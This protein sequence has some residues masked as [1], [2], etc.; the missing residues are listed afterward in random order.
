MICGGD[1]YAQNDV[2]VS[3][4]MS[5]LGFHFTNN[6]TNAQ[7]DW[8][9]NGGSVQ[10]DPPNL[11]FS[12]TMNH[13]IKAHAL[14]V[15]SDDRMKSAIRDIADEEALTQL[16][17]IKPMIYGYKDKYENGNVKTI[18]YI[19]QQIKKIIPQAVSLCR[20]AI[21]NILTPAFVYMKKDTIELKL[22][23][24]LDDDIIL[25]CGSFLQVNIQDQN[26]EFALLSASDESII[27]AIGNENIDGVHDGTKAVIY[28]EV[29]DDFHC[30]DESQIF[31]ITTAAVQ[32][33]DRQLEAEKAKTALLQ[34]QM[35]D[36]LNRLA[37][38]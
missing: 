35:T 5:I 23:L 32:E 25:K 18:G 22:R 15:T 10:A 20:Q 16:R 28:G 7:S 24:P 9:T 1:L 2:V 8:L 13:S 4:G 3:G 14:V 33:L 21:P 31:T 34:Q 27:V 6:Y 30:I 29:V 12:V 37:K 36:V 19:A 38:K 17:Q 26:Y 11:N